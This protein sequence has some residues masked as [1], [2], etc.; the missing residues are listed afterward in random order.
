[1]ATDSPY[2]VPT[3]V[4]NVGGG[5]MGQKAHSLLLSLLKFLVLF[6]YNLCFPKKTQLDVVIY[7]SM[8]LMLVMTTAAI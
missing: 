8:L 2:W 4:Y 7:A 3:A 5:S 6:S 1:M